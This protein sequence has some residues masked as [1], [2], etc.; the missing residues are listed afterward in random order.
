MRGQD[1]AVITLV[2]DNVDEWATTLR[3]H[4][5]AIEKGPVLNERY[6]IYHIFFRD[7]DGPFLRL[8]P[9]FTP[10]PSMC[11]MDCGFPLAGAFFCC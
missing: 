4:G 10:F 2:T 1:G 3:A 9:P 6:K 7:P 5:V 11:T 8:A